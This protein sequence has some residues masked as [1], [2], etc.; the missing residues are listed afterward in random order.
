MLELLQWKA[1]TS[2]A[3]ELVAKLGEVLRAVLTQR[4]RAQANEE[5]AAPRDGDEPLPDAEDG[6]P[7]QPSVGFDRRSPALPF[8]QLGLS[9]ALVVLL[10]L[11]CSLVLGHFCSC[12]T[13]TA[14]TSFTYQ[15]ML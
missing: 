2:G 3:A 5:A 14:F 12:S 7:E 6:P 10:L 11:A 1:A 8:S 9:A 4:R 15:R 13:L